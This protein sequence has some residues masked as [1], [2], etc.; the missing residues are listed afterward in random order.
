[1]PLRDAKVAME[2]ISVL[3]LLFK[4]NESNQKDL[5]GLKPST[6]RESSIANSRE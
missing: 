1:M 6:E 5:Q 3:S 4:N 2:D